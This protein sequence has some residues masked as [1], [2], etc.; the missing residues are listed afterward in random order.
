MDK[1]KHQK[2]PSKFMKN[3]VNKFLFNFNSS[4]ISEIL[5]WS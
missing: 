3:V 4:L 5:Y 2:Q 1:Q